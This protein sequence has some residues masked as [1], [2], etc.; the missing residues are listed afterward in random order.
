[1]DELADMGIQEIGDIPA[2]FPLSQIQDRIRLSVTNQQEYISKDLKAE[3]NDVKYPIHFLDFETI[4]LALPR[5]ADTRPYQTIPFQ[6]SDHILYENGK[7]DHREYLCNEDK[8]PREEFT[9]TL[10][11]ALGTEGSIVIYTSYETGV[12]NSLIE[13]FPQY[14][15]VLQS[16]IDRFIDLYA[17]I[18]RHY[19]H[20]KFYGSFSLKNVLPALVPEMRYE[21]LSIQEGM[22]ASIEYLRMIDSATPEE[23]KA[24]IRQDLL[25]YCGQDTLAMVKI[26]DKLLSR[27]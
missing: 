22:Q 25:T 20:P 8:D 27:A 19:Y 11:D 5:Y 26:R 9:Q 1:L 10:L 17:I 12:L 16:V 18:R 4:G 15:D 24:R 7:L 13:H 6:W 14:A 23:E 3:L 21:N 2:T